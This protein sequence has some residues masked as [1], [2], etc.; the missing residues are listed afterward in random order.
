MSFP[1][2][3]PVESFMKKKSKLNI[4]SIN[5]DCRSKIEC[6]HTK[7]FDDLDSMRVQSSL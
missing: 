1:I 3:E 2:I 4:G 5:E 7:I 6:L